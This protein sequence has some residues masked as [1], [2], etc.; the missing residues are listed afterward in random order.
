M[1]YRNKSIEKAYRI[2][3]LFDRETL[4][5]SATEIARRLTTTPSAI[6]PI[7]CTL[8]THGYLQR[9][10]NKKYA[11][12]YKFLERANLVLQQTDLYTSAKPHLKKLASTWSVNTHLGIFYADMVLYLHRE[13]GGDTVI[14]GEITGWQEP[15]Y[16]TAL[17]KTLLAFLPGPEL[18]S[19]LSRERLTAVTPYTI[20]DAVK[21]RD[22]LVRIRQAAF[23]ISN[24]EA[25]EGVIG[26]GAPVTDFKGEVRAAISISVPKSRWHK[27][28]AALIAAVRQT[29]CHLSQELGAVRKGKPVDHV[30]YG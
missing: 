7:L 15:A 27:E 26:V 25:H 3:D 14:I 5:L 19:Y 28:Q 8:E 12:G 1:N 4:L 30:L 20:V 18:E 13:V 9:D 23:A 29:A 22:E 11:L 16:C 10:G 17:G 2:F 24:E 21:L 6:Y